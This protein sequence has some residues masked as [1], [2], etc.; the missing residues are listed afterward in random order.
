M[1]FKNYTLL[2]LFFGSLLFS[3]NKTAKLYRQEEPKGISLTEFN[4]RTGDKNKIVLVYFHADWCVV[5]AKMKPIIQK[6]DS[7]YQPQLEIL[8]IDTD[9]DKEVADEFEINSLPVLMLY[10]HGNRE[11]TRIGIL[12]EKELTEDLNKY[13]LPNH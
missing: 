13:I 7:L 3:S 8:N 6:I 5:C 10:K 11:W 1:S 12:S 2:I 9:R 4:K